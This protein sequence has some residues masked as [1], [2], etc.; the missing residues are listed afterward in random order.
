MPVPDDRFELVVLA[1]HRPVRVAVEIRYD[2][3][4]LAERWAQVL[5]TVFAAFD[6]DRDGYLNAVEMRRVFSDTSAASLLQNGFYTPFPNDLPT[7]AWLDADRDGKVSFAEFAGYY[8][9]AAVAAAQT[10]L[11]QPEN[12]Q[13]SAA[14]EELFKLIDRDKDGKLSRAEVAAAETWVVARDTDEDECLSLAEILGNVQVG[15]A[16]PVVVSGSGRMP[17][18]TSPVS[19]HRPGRAPDPIRDRFLALYDPG[20]AGRFT[21][22]NLGLDR[23]TF[24]RLDADGDGSLTPGEAERWW[25]GPADAEVLLSLAAKTQDCRVTVTADAAALAARGFTVAQSEPQRLVLRHGRQ[26]IEFAASSGT[27]ARQAAL[28]QSFLGQF[29]QAAKGK[30]F[31]TETDLGGQNAPQYQ[32]LRVMFDAADADADGKLSR[33]ELV[34]HLALMEAFA[35]G[36]MALTPAVQTPTLFQLLD[37]N[38]DGRLSVRELRTAWDRLAVLEPA[39]AGGRVDAIT[40]A[41]I[42][43]T[44][45]LRLTR[46]AERFAVPQPVAGN[47]Q[48]PPVPQAGPVWFRRMDRNG[49]GDVSRAEFLGTRAEFDAMDTDHDGLISLREA[50]AFDATMRKP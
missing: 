35:S 41:A 5:K 10:S 50:E 11:P 23:D 4:P 25:T 40:R 30:G 27:V 14:T 12:A 16:I 43:P 17:A 44:A 39:G 46:L 1:P 26:P 3:K 32:L 28:R 42:Q 19:V 29:D 18:A 7:V 15:V 37:D 33:S 34:D 9:Q 22:P 6:R 48:S 47:N 2:G 20:K 31:V 13:N 38:R 24:A 36:A 8:R 21:P 45:T 49:D